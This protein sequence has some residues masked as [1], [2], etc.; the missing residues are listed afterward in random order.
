M[1]TLENELKKLGYSD[2]LIDAITSSTEME[3]SDIYIEMAEY[4]TYDDIVISTNDISITECNTK[5]DFL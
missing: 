5:T 3:C 4:Q 1:K 2:E